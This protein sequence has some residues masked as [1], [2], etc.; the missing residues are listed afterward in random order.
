MYNEFLHKIF[1]YSLFPLPS[2]HLPLL[3]FGYLCNMNPDLNP[4]Y[5]WARLTL[6]FVYLV[7]LAGAVVRATGSGMGCPDWPKCFGRWVPPTSESQ[8]PANY[9]E[10]YKTQTYENV[11][12]NPAQTWTEAINRYVGVSLGIIAFIGLIYAFRLRKTHKQLFILTLIGF[13]LIGFEGWLG[14]KVVSSN[15]AP[16][17]IT[18]HMLVALAIMILYIRVLF[19]AR[20]GKVFITEN[21]RFRILILVAIVFTVVQILLGTQVREQVDE[22][23]SNMAGKNRHLWADLLNAWFYI[24]RTFSVLLLA[25]NIYLYWKLRGTTVTKT[26]NAVAVIILLEVAAGIVLNYFSFPPVVQPAHLILSCILFGLQAYL[27]MK[28]RVTYS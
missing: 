27:F 8:L 16:V 25:L 13:L 1:R 28:V 4:F 7:I 2:F 12:F 15:L 24:H 23:Y 19:L 22:L 18:I 21:P 3:M 14:A 26:V 6:V 5:R 11:V 10:I 17:K 9:K 20:P